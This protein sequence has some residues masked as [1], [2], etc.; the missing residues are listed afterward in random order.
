MS[1][2]KIGLFIVVLLFVLVLLTWP[3]VIKT[4]TKHRKIMNKGDEDE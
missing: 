2:I 1:G 4:E 3:K